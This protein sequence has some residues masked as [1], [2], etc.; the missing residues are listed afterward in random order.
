[1]KRQQQSKLDQKNLLATTAKSDRL[2]DELLDYQKLKSKIEIEMDVYESTIS[3]CKN[4][5]LV[6]REELYKL[7]KEVDLLK[8]VNENLEKEKKEIESQFDAKVKPIRVRIE[9]LEEDIIKGKNAFKQK[10]EDLEGEFK[11]KYDEEEELSKKKIMDWKTQFTDDH[12]EEEEN[13]KRINNSIF[14]YEEKLAALSDKHRLQVTD[15]AN[16]LKMNNGAINKC[17][18]LLSLNKICRD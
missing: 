14:A 4:S 3:T 16:E 12:Y 13:L 7:T 10:L 11:G 18:D 1:M 2:N 9:K 15:L 5:L 6:K 8:H 17:K